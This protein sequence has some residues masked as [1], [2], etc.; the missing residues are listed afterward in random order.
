[1]EEKSIEANYQSAVLSDASYV[2]WFDLNG[3]IRSDVDLVSDLRTLRAFTESEARKFISRYEPVAYQADLKSGFS[4]TIY[5][6]NEG[7]QGSHVMAIRGTEITDRGDIFADLDLA[8]ISG[9]ATAQYSQLRQFIMDNVHILSSGALTVSG[10]SLGGYLAMKLA[11]DDSLGQGVEGVSIEHTY[12]Y[13][14]PGLGRPIFGGLL[15]DLMEFLGIDGSAKL[16]SVTNLY[17]TTGLEL[18]TGLGTIYGDEIPVFIEANGI[19]S[20]HYIGP[21]NDALS[22]YRILDLLEPISTNDEARDYKEIHRVLEAV[23]SDDDKTFD[24]LLQ[25]LGKLFGVDSAYAKLNEA[26]KFFEELDNKLRLATGPGNYQI[27]SL[28]SEVVGSGGAP[29]PLTTSLAPAFN[30]FGATGRA[31]RQC[32]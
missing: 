9:S 11:V 24:S 4:A 16:D 14:A 32:H 3:N 19:A 17:G 5:S 25:S 18:T 8:L 21:L 13:N 6:D 1:M 10:H 29:L 2:A 31:Y 27:H 15:T 7:V 12:T 22:V 20:T 30:D 28:E 23:Q 26:V